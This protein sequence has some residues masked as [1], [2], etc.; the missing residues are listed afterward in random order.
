MVVDLDLD[1]DVDLDFV[2]EMSNWPTIASELTCNQGFAVK[3][4]SLSSLL[5]R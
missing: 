1:L 3:L 5:T 4:Y 2:V